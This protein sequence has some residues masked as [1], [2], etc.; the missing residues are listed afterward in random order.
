MREILDTGFGDDDGTVSP[1]VAEILASEAPYPEKLAVIQQAR[2]LVPVVATLGEVEYDA[3][4]RA[5]DKTSDMATVLLQG[6]DG[7]LALLAFTCVA[8]M[9]AWDSEARP[10]PVGMQAACASA[11]QDS[12]SAL[13]IDV[14]GPHMFVIE[15]DDLA[16]LAAGRQLVAVG[17]R[18]AWAQPAAPPEG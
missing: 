10:V 2:L 7:R 12:A 4:G 17:E 18:Y 6:R 11:L 3:E 16:E 5:R 15:A 1:R 14:A 13:V 9:H 8:S